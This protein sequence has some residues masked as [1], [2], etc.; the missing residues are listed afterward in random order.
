MLCT[1]PYSKLKLTLLY[2][3]YFNIYIAFGYKSLNYL[4]QEY[5]IFLMERLVGNQKIKITPRKENSGF[6]FLLQVLFLK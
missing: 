5:Y 4:E 2:S 1:S 3:F 6:H